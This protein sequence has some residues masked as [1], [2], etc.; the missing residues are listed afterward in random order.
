MMPWIEEEILTII[1]PLPV[2]SILRHKVNE[3]SFTWSCVVDYWWGHSMAIIKSAQNAPT[4]SEAR[5]LKNYL[6]DKGIKVGRWER[7]SGRPR[8]TKVRGK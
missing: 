3:E 5:L 1:G 8:V 2:N 4:L 7:K 6:K